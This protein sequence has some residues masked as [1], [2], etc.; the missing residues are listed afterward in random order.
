MVA[1]RRKVS[2]FATR[3]SANHGR[4]VANEVLKSEVKAA[5]S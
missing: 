1:V 2:P 3:I 5:G 4:G